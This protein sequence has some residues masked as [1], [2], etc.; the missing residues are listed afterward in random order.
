MLFP[1]LPSRVRRGTIEVDL[2]WVHEGTDDV[3]TLPVPGEA[4]ITV[5]GCTGHVTV[6]RVPTRDGQFAHLPDGPARS[7]IHV[8]TTPADPDADRQL[9]YMPPAEN[10]RVGMIVT[11]CVGQLPT[12]EIPETTEELRAVSFR[13]GTVQVR[14]RWRLDMPLEV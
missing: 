3:V 8:A 6:T 14:G 12:V 11:H 5:A 1:A 7:A 10:A 13:G 9:V 4:D 2:V